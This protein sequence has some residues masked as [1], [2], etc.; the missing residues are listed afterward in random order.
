[1]K[2]LN[3]ILK[4]GNLPKQHRTG[5]KDLWN[6]FMVDGAL[7]SSHDIP[8]CPTHI[9][10]G[11]P[12]EL[13]SFA[14]AKTLYN[15]EIRKGKKEFH[16]NAWIHFYCD[17]QYFDG[18][19]NSIWHFPKKALT[20]IRQ[21]NGIITPDFSTYSDFPDPIKRYNTYRMRAF[22]YW[23]QSMGIP[24]LNNVRWGTSETW[25]YCF[26][27]IEKG[28]VI[29]IGT[30]AS[31]LREIENRF[32]FY[33]GFYEMI[34]ILTPKTIIV[35]GSSRYAALQKAQEKGIEIITFTSQTNAAHLT[36]KGGDM[37]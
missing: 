32:D 1:M 12:K 29:C 5:C 31:G 24:V 6:A 37:S 11:L 36:K 19:H 28:T 16:H 9:P 30:V 14:E 8:F 20:I 25:E 27:G 23:C 2:N 15:K 10:D 34:R 26:D 13:I 4:Q 17:D 18:I 33:E 3:E 35:Y 22:G 7:F 21:F